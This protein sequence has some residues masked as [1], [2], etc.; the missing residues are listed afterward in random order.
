[1]TENRKEHAISQGYNFVNNKVSQFNR[2]D[3]DLLCRLQGNLL[4]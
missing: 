4:D 2:K 1:M 3:M